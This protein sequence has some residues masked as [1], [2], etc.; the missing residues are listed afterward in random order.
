MENAVGFREATITAAV[1]HGGIGGGNEV[2]LDDIGDLGGG[3]SQGY[4]A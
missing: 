1:E 3:S 4:G 2:G